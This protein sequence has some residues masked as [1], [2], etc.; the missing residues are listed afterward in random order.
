MIKSYRKCLMIEK[1][2]KSCFNLTR[3]SSE[4]KSVTEPRKYMQ[5]NTEEQEEL[6]KLKDN[7]GKK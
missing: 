2:K 3:F 7:A 5:I 1:K 4:G 6:F